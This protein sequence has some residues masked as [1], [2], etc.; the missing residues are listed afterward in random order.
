MDYSFAELKKKT[1]VDVADG[2]KIGKVTDV[3]V[4]FPECCLKSLTVSPPICLSSSEKRIVTPCEIEKIG[5]DV[6]LLK[7]RRGCPPPPPPPCDD[8]E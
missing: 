1:V 8:D 4:S 3:T 7:K 6:I 5:E 2:S